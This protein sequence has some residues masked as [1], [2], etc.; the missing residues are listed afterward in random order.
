MLD[1]LQQLLGLTSGVQPIPPISQSGQD[2]DPAGAAATM[3]AQKA[4]QQLSQPPQGAQAG[5]PTQGPQQGPQMPPS[6]SQ[7]PATQGQSGLDQLLGI[8]IPLLGGLGAAM[9]TPRLMGP[10]AKFGAG[11]STAAPL[12]MR[13]RQ[14]QAQEDLRR[15]LMGRELQHQQAIEQHQQFMEKATSDRLA[16]ELSSKLPAG[17]D[18]AQSLRI[19]PTGQP[20]PATKGLPSSEIMS[21]FPAEIQLEMINATT[22][23]NDMEQRGLNAAKAH[24]DNLVLRQQGYDLQAE[25]IRGRM[26]DAEARLEVMKSAHQDTTAIQKEIV[27]LR[28]QQADALE[29]SKDATNLLK[30]RQSY[31]NHPIMNLRTSFDDYARAS[32]FD[33]ETGA[34]LKSAKGVKPV[35]VPNVDDFLKKYNIP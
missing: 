11:L 4:Q 15:E 32:G 29:E 20:N 1:L 18:L 21:K 27:G 8:A 10:G 31:D 17:V 7:G 6:G 26:A 2:L 14:I 3:A 5:Q 16:L 34:K 25:S 30:L 19:S 28:K 22:K 24:Q 33:P 9:T 13:M 35:T 12:F 23:A